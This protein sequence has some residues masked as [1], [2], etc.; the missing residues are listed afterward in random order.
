MKTKRGQVT[1]FIIIAVV[2]V[3]F[4]ALAYM[5]YPK[6]KSNFQ[7]ETKN[8]QA[9]ISE[10]V[11]DELN[12]YVDL[13]SK[14]GGSL[15]PKLYLPY[16][17]YNTSYLCHTPENYLSCAPKKPF[18]QKDIED[19]LTRTIT[20]QV[21]ACF[22]SLQLNYEGK[23][24]DVQMVPGKIKIKLLPKKIIGTFDYKVTL[25]KDGTETYNLFNI[26]LDN[27]LYE[28]I[29][30]SDIIVEWAIVYGKID[31][32][33]IMAAYSYIDVKREYPTW[34]DVI[35]ILKDKEVGGEFRV[36]TRSFAYPP[37]P[38]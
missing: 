11:E 2:V 30:I 29:K 35:Y 13:I 26:M 21:E 28:L 36:L 3:A 37:V 10:C 6:I 23:G 4:I 31:P 9:F 18:L 33:S 16:A 15:D 8:P 5:V 1:I 17:G 34:G 14:Q 7:T 32:I 38:S 25:T 27:N 12:E 19:E 22:N 20:P 24:Y